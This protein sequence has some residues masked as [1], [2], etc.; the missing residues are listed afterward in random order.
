MLGKLGSGFD[1]VSG[2][3]LERVLAADKTRRRPRRLLWRR[4]DSCRDG[5][6]PTLRHLDVQRR[7][8][9]RK[10]NFSPSERAKLKKRARV[11]VR[12]N[13]DVFAETHPYISTG[14]HKHKFGVPIDEAR[15]LYRT[16]AA[17]II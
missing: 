13:P 2:G 12:V 9:S 1:I 14:L 5:P 17:S 10:L 7:E 8:R 4:Q 15:G 16:I 11:A 6:C 3:E